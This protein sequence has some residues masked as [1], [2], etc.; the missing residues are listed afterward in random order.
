ML[1]E[2]IN[3]VSFHYI[4]AY[5]KHTH[6]YIHTNTHTGGTERDTYVYAFAC[7]DIMLL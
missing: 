5:T 6:T 3:R 7:F 4:I 1:V 2:A